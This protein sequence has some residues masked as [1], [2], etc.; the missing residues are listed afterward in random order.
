[1]LW[2]V[3]HELRRAGVVR[4][5]GER[6]GGDDGVLSAPGSTAGRLA[7]IVFGEWGREVRHS[8]GRVGE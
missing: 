6:W 4:G 7:G 8:V 5:S 3:N 2:W 1:M